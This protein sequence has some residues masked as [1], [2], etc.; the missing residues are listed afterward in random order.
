MPRQRLIGP[1]LTRA[2]DAGIQVLDADNRMV[3][4][5]FSSETP[6][7][8]VSWFDDPWIEVLGHKAEEVDLAR[9]TSKAAPVL[10]GHNP[11]AR[12]AHVGVVE[13]GWLQDGRGYADIRF[14]KRDDV[15]DLWRD[16]TDGIVRNISVGYNI[17]ERVLTKKSDKLPSEYRVTRWI[18]ME[19]SFVA[20]PADATVGVGRSDDTPEKHFIITDLREQEID[21][22]RAADDAATQAEPV[23]GAAAA[24]PTPAPAAA[25][26]DEKA[27]REAATT[28]ERKR[29][30]DI[31]DAVTRS[32]APAEIATKAIAEGL[33]VEQVRA[34]VID[35]FAS[36]D[37]HHNP[38]IDAVED[39]A[40]KYRAGAE[41]WLLYRCREPGADG[42]QIAIGNSEFR[43]LS[44]VDLAVRALAVAGVS[45]RG[46]SRMEIVG[47]AIT[48]TTSDFPVVLQ[49]VMHKTLLG[50]YTATPNVWPRFCARG[51]LSDFRPHYRYRMGSFNDLADV[52]EANEFQDGTLP[53]AERESITAKTKGRILNLSRQMIINDDMGAFTGVSRLMGRAAART[54][55]KDVFAMILLGAGLGPVLSDGQTV[56]HATHNNIAAV[57]AAPSVLSFD[58]ARV[59]MASQTDVGGLEIIDVRPSLWLGPLSLEGAA[60]VVNDSQYDPDANNKLQRP[61][62]SRGLFSDIVGTPRLTGTR[63]YAFANPGEE[64]CY[65]VGFLDGQETPVLDQQEGFRVDGMSW[66]VRLDYGVA[67]VGFRGGVTN[68]GA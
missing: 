52:T 7:K 35:H 47:R 30:A 63:W 66:K 22:P 29:V 18:P 56:F 34:Q 25:T 19:I 58:A 48:H 24:A 5:S 20:I 15:A 54:V 6:Y 53:D 57:A 32:K 23:A 67:A 62:I 4:V 49:N 12:A 17:L 43:G 50:S 51:N 9:L 61:N 60:K 42:K 1:M 31:N 68:A 65:E 16:V 11:Y 27:V 46:L 44:L 3:R 40:D 33:T 14:S 45:T 37:V 8:R 41:V 13:N 38:R 10:Y 21:M 36:R 26:V 28:A 39:G 55:E 2:F 64:P 59:Q